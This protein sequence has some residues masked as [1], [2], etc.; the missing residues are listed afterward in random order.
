[1]PL[2]GYGVAADFVSI[3]GFLTF[4]TRV[5]DNHMAAAKLVSVSADSATTHACNRL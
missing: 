3:S 5:L 2:A 1:V 4:S